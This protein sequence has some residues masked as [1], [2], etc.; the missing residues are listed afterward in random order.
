M[1]P[2]PILPALEEG[3]ELKRVLLLVDYSNILYRS[4]FSSLNGSE[5]RPWLPVLR[6]LDSLRLCIQRANPT[7]VPVEIIF[8]G[9]SRKKLERTKRDQTYKSTRIPVTHEIF[10]NFRK[11]LALILDDMDSRIVSRDGAEA[12]DVIASIANAVC[13]LDDPL[14]ESSPTTTTTVIFSNDKD[15]YQLLKYKRCYVYKNPGVFYTPKLFEVEFGFTPKEYPLYK[16]MVG[17][18][19]DDIS[20]VQGIG[21]VTARKH[22]LEGTV[23]FDDPEFQKALDLI[24]LDYN[25]DVPNV[26]DRLRFDLTLSR[27]ENY[28]YKYYGKDTEAYDEIVLAMKMLYAAYYRK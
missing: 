22:I 3:E 13:K 12:D 16:A 5:G 19:S 2:S 8:A 27:S 25:L 18:K 17:D 9:E 20:G 10:R 21:P 1:K 4:Y 26:G 11:I 28:I 14:M 23:P 6:F 24:E 7:G 15:I